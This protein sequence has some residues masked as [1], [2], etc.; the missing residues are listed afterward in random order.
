M[1]ETAELVEVARRFAA[2]LDAC[3]FAL[4]ERFLAVNCRYDGPR[5]T[6]FGPSAIVQSYRQSDAWGRSTFDG[7]EYRSEA[8]PEGPDAVR[9]TYI[10]EIRYGNAEHTYRCSQLL[11]FDAQRKIAR[12]EHVELS[13]ERDRMREF[14]TSHGITWSE[15]VP[16]LA[17]S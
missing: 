7:I 17:D 8:V 2:A 13:G 14:C 9:L 12:I 16:P 3:D 11:Y 15:I 4:A 1:S 10:D 5:Q 6:C